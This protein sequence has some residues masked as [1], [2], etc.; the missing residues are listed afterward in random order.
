MIL[1]GNFLEIAA[2][3]LLCFAVAAAAV[4][5]R[6]RR[7]AWAVSATRAMHA[8]ALLVTLA[9]A[10]LV[11]ALVR[12]DFRLEYVAE[13]TSTTLPM[14]YTVTAFWAG[15][16]GSLLLWLWLLLGFTSLALWMYGRKYHPAMPHFILFTG[17]TAV[18]FN[19]M[20]LLFSN[21]F[22]PMEV[23]VADG[24]GLNPLLQNVGMIFHPPTLYVGYVGFTIPFAF[25][26][27]CLCAGHFA[28]EWMKI[29][30]KWSLVSWVF[31]TV[32]IILGA[33]W[34]Y[35]E[36]GWGGYWAWDPVEN[37]SFI[38]WIAATAFL[39]TAV[40]QE[41]RGVLKKW[42][43][44][45]VMFTFL[46][47]VFGTFITRSG[48]VE[49][50]HAFG[51][52]NIGYYFLGFMLLML[53]VGSGVIFLRRAALQ[54]DETL[55]GMFSKEGTFVL[56]NL[57]LMAF[58]MVVFVGT[59][60]PTLTEAF[61]GHKVSVQA[62]FFNQAVVPF[63][64]GMLLLLGLC[65]VMGWRR[66]SA[67]LF[68]QNAA[69]F[70]ALLLL[71]VG[72][73]AI[74]AGGR[75]MAVFLLGLGAA[76]AVAILLDYGRSVLIRRR[77]AGEA[78][79]LAAVNL[80]RKNKRRYGAYIV[81]LGVV[82]LCLGVVGSAYFSR[83]YEATVRTGEEFQAGPFRL[84]YLSFHQLSD[85]EKDVL[86]AKLEVFHSGRKLGVMEPEKHFHRLFEQPMTEVA[87]RST[88]GSDL[89]IIYT[90]LEVSGRAH[91][92]VLI[93]PMVL[94]IWIGGILMTL[95]GLVALLPNRRQSVLQEL[96][97]EVA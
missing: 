38:P 29:M 44:V 96:P 21:P 66:T 73:A 13:Y 7:E 94:W 30:R 90:P 8:A 45:L 26:M 47:C 72:L 33:Q 12:R 34:A 68:W 32:G 69:V 89:Y 77:L 48:F 58:L 65:L 76:V 49:S 40:L 80:F 2:L 83:T 54:P 86:Q 93:N 63:T 16:A 22:Q 9:A 53:A 79:P 19:L 55:G 41:R 95:G 97:P 84:H 37:A 74:W 24:R 17:G 3:A 51:R 25:A 28:P 1:F 43:A 10:L 36:L 78:L 42:N 59:I 15:Q 71:G 88:A 60:F 20:L 82:S 5:L 61:F 52:S 31:L 70:F 91:F 23:A 50:V 56:T 81:H 87:I 57:L 35:V 11:V 85:P 14:V 39:H 6:T 4:H 64:A 27:A 92:Q 75:I 46:L 62:P 18:F 67:R